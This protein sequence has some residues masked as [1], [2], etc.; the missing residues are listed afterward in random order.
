MDWIT[1]NI[2]IG[3]FLDAKKVPSVIDAILCLK[4]G[5]FCQSREDV[6]A[7]CVPLIDGSGN[8][9]K[10]VEEAI[11]AIKD[12]VQEGGKTGGKI[13]VHC[14]AGQSRSVCIVAAYLM[15]RHEYSDEY[16]R[17]TKDEALALIKE[18]RGYSLSIGIEEIFL[19]AR[20]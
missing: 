20:R 1:E 12:V 4:E 10:S 8:S 18:K 6:D 5:C 9:K 19:L 15:R 2:A 17:M 14:H 7:F 13:L 3:N 16:K 11:N